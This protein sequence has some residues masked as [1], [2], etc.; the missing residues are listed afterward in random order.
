MEA[1]HKV[2]VVRQTE[3]AALKA[4]S[5]N[6]S[7]PFTRKLTALYTKSTFVMDDIDIRPDLVVWFFLGVCGG[8]GKSVFALASSAV[9]P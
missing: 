8:G 7:T 1:G 6:K 3:T 2:G 4:A 9:I 5:T